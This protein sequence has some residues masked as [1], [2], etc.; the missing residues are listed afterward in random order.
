MLLAVHVLL[1]G[2]RGLRSL[3]VYVE[4][5]A[6]RPAFARSHA[7]PA[8]LYRRASLWTA[9][10]TAIAGDLSR[11]AV[12]STLCSNAHGQRLYRLPVRYE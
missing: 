1:A 11:L 6:S 7:Q 8:L 3:A 4:A 12:S 5:L 10:R 2:Q 9:T